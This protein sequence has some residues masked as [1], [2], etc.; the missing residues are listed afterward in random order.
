[1]DAGYKT[2]GPLYRY[3]TMPQWI[4]MLEGED[5]DDRAIREAHG[6]GYTEDWH[7]LSILCQKGC[8]LTYFDISSGKVRECAAVLDMRG[9]YGDIVRDILEAL[10]ERESISFAD[11]DRN[12]ELAVRLHIGHVFHL[13]E[14]SDPRRV[15]QDL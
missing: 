11:E 8:K 9:V 3:M 6:I 12:Y 7:D 4:E 10:C 2:R 15:P 1:M 5:P 13:G 14:D